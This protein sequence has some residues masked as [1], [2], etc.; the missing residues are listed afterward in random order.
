MSILQRYVAAHVIVG[1]LLAL[2]I[3]IALFTFVSFVDDLDTVGKGNYTMTRA[4]EYLALTTPRT[5]FTVFPLAALLGSL[6]GL[7]ALSSNFELAVIRA[8]GVSTAQILGAV[9]K[10]G[11]VLMIA[12]VLIGELAVPH[13]ERAARALRAQ[14]LHQML[15]VSGSR[16]FWARDGQSYI[17]VKRILPGR[18]IADL[19]V[20]EL[21]V[22]RRLRVATHAERARFRNGKWELSGV[23]QSV[24]GER[25][26]RART[27]DSA[28]WVSKFEPSLLN[29]IAVKPESLS[30]VGLVHYT[31]YLRR[32]GLDA[33]RFELAFWNKLV[34]PLATGV[35]IFLAVPLDLGRLG[36]ASLGQRIVVGV[37]AGITFHVVNQAS[38]QIG[39]VYGLSPFGSAVFPTAVF[40]AFGLWR[41]RE[42]R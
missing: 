29:V 35:M 40:L 16:G 15:T 27:L 21:D 10:G 37:L 25:T 17:N 9:L 13:A 8:S 1:T 2:V 31:R 23:R 11:G 28:Q 33:A 18:Q 36:T 19:F 24:I 22:Q 30:A 12:A 41:L 42:V 6:V 38:G 3:L 32:N 5:A 39:V 34:Y 4:L 26:V 7:G 20:Y 14:A